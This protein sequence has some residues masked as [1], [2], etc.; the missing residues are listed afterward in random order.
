MDDSPTANRETLAWIAAQGLAGT[1]GTESEEGPAPAAPAPPAES[2]DRILQ[3]LG[4]SQPQRAIEL[5]MRSADQEKSER[6]RFLRRA[7]AARVMVETGLEAVA[8]PVL[9]RMAE[10]IERHQLEEWETGQTVAGALGLLYRCMERLGTDSGEREALYLRICRL[11]PLQ[12]IDFR[13]REG[14]SGDE[15]DGGS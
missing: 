5:L 2:V 12:A 10:Q 4:T 14:S 6:G 8:E 11:D 13:G 15:S 7:D 3:R 9:R 1:D